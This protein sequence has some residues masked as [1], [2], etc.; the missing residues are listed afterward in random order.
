MRGRYRIIQ[1]GQGAGKTYG[2]LSI[3]IDL[4]QKYKGG[5]TFH[6]IVFR[7]EL[8][9]AKRTI[10]KDFISLMKSLDFWGIGKWNKTT[11][12]YA[13]LNGASIEFV[14]LDK[15]DIGKGLRP[16]VVYFNEANEG[17]SYETFQQAS[18][19]VARVYI[20]YNPDTEFWAHDEIM[21]KEDFGFLC[22]TYKDNEAISKH[23]LKAILGYREKGY[24][25]ISA[26]ETENNIK[27]KY[28]ANKWR[29]YGLGLVGKLEG[30]IFDYKI[31]QTIPSE[32]KLIGRGIDFGF[33]NADNAD[34]TAIVEL[35]LL[36]N[37]LYLKELM[38]ATGVPSTAIKSVIDS[39]PQCMNIADG[40]GGGSFRI[41]ELA[42]IGLRNI[43]A[44]V[45][46]A[47]SVKNGIDLLQGYEIYIEANSLN[48]IKEAKGYKYHPTTRLPIDKD[49]H[50][51]DGARYVISYHTVTHRIQQPLRGVIVKPN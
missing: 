25:D 29:V 43:I 14:G 18:S 16:D 49:N 28:W 15:K 4:C 24:Y 23:E 8:S 46:D 19:R 47:G 33:S 37:K 21:A 9:K 45:K 41:T 36:G 11:S 2:I 26:G 5:E 20:D 38:Y 48:M 1:G 32:A 30:Q 31:V 42:R 44:A 39:R 3:L 35:Y 13:F 12:T 50:L 22:L 34:P 6:V 17:I 10:V 40:G 7:A 51:W 27:N